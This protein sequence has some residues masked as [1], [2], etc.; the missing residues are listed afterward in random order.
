[1]KT[2]PVLVPLLLAL[3]V[4]AGSA[5]AARPAPPRL[6]GLGISNGGHPF[7]GDT[8]ELATVSPNGDGLRD[9]AL[10]H[11]RLDR[12]GTVD[13]QVVATDEVRR[14][15]RPVWEIRRHLGAGP[16]SIRWTPRR[17]IAAR[18]YL[19]RFR[20]RGAGGARVYGFEAPRPHRLTSGLVVR[21]LGVEASFMRRSYPQGGPA[22][23]SIATDAP[24]IR[25]QVFSYEGQGTRDPYTEG[26]AMTP[27]IRLGWRDHR[28]APFSVDV[29]RQ[30]TW[31]SGLYFLR[32]QASDG[33]LAYA[34][35]ILRPRTPGQHRVA[36]V[37]PTNTWQAY[38]FRDGNG[39]GWADSWYIGGAT[40]SI[41]LRRPYVEPGL[42]YRFHDW[43]ASFA[44]W[45]KTSGKQ[46]DYFS[47]DDIEAFK[48]GD[49]LRHAYRLVVF[50]GHE[51][52]VTTH[53]YDVVQRYRDL[54]GNLMFMSANN[55]FWKVSLKGQ[56]LRR[57]Q[58][59][60][61]L[62]RPEAALVGVQFV[63]G[64]YGQN[65]KPYVVERASPWFDGT[66]LAGGSLFGRGGV[67]VDVRAPSSPG[68]I[69][70]LAR[71]PNAIG[72]HD[73]EMTMYSSAAGGQVFAAGSLDFPA[74]IEM[75]GVG[76]LVDNVWLAL[77]G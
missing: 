16:H 52:Y 56:I 72:P 68:N 71:I 7:A 12:P 39:D 21:I 44:A 54:G 10:V 77:S 61:K 35:F 65:E 57:V 27:P 49:E 47:D 67:E 18:T 5:P 19:V 62:G 36:V 42:P 24:S 70:V 8:R 43:S 53:A 9:Y 41:D 69:V 15:A 66:G 45:L 29:G 31:P 2:L 73:A 46:A 3:V 13:M 25:I 74:S 6:L 30:G 64:N 63:A 37:L 11:F 50:S 22:T 4:A 26:F 38:N 75:P 23:V 17:N 59:W 60:R 32:A 48:T 33:R 76:Q 34:P 14:P 20:V 55:F 1:V 51:E 58:Q 40:R 28:S